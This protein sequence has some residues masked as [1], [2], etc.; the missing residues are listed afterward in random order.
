MTPP[1]QKPRPAPRRTK[2]YAQARQGAAAYK[3]AL[4][5]FD[6]A[7]SQDL[8]IAKDRL[9]EFLEERGLAADVGRLRHANEFAIFQV[10][11]DHLGEQFFKAKLRA[12]Q[13]VLDITPDSPG[14]KLYTAY[15]RAHRAFYANTEVAR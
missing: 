14:L 6:F 8:D 3:L 11:G 9:A 7:D 1:R 12:F 5:G 4:M 13:G 10:D 2:V 15:A